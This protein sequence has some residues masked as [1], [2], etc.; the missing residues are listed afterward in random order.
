M[1]VSQAERT[2]APAKHSNGGEFLL[3][4]G[5]LA[6]TLGAALWLASRNS[7]AACSP[8]CTGGQSCVN[9]TCTASG[10]CPQVDGFCVT[11]AP[12]GMLVQDETTTISIINPQGQRQGFTEIALVEG[13]GYDLD[14]LVQIGGPRRESIP[15]GAVISTAGNCPPQSTSSSAVVGV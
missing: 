8:A 12:P 7:G 4:G 15:L 3:V 6:G 14:R 2:A 9:G 10:T 11:G 5:I 1:A 13:C